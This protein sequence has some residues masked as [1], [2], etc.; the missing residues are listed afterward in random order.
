MPFAMNRKRRGQQAPLRRATAS[1]E[2]SAN[3]SVSH[4]LLVMIVAR[5]LGV[6][7]AIVRNVIGQ[8]CSFR[9]AA[10]KS[11]LLFR[12]LNHP[13]FIVVVRVKRLPH[14]QTLTSPKSAKITL[15]PDD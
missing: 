8:S 2:C 10:L 11:R 1:N 14:D 13:S 4:N 5:L 15:K 9:S 12:T 6:F 7:R 3:Q